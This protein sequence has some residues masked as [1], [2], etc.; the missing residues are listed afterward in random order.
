MS[1]LDLNVFFRDR[2]YFKETDK[3]QSS[4]HLLRRDIVQCLG[5]QPDAEIVDD[6]ERVLLPALW[7]A[8]VG[9]M[10]GID[11]LAK[12]RYGKETSSRS[13]FERFLEDYFELE[14]PKT[15]AVVLY[16]LRSALVHSFSMFAEDPR[17]SKIYRFHVD[18]SRLAA[19]VRDAGNDVFIVGL[20]KLHEKFEASIVTYRSDLEQGKA[21]TADFERVYR[22]HGMIPWDPIPV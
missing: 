9:I 5:F 7:P 17:T 11:L 22:I 3:P 8:A 1:S 4:L 16:Q 21:L 10:T 12:H 13:V 2:R 14:D 20:W 18:P 6:S 19:L 15:D